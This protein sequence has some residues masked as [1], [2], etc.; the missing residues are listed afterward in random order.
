MEGMKLKDPKTFEEQLSIL[1][2]RHMIV[3][4]REEALKILS[5]TNY[6]RLT[7]YA[8]Q[9]KANDD[10]NKNITFNEMYDLYKFDKKLRSLLR[11]V[12]ESIEISVRTFIAYHLSIKY[13][14]SDIHRDSSI[15][16]DVRLHIGYDDEYGVHHT[17]LLEELNHEINKNRKEPLV[18]HHI[19]KYNRSFPTWAIVE[20]MSFGMLS[21]MYANLNIKDQK[22]ISRNG[23]NTNNNL[24]ESWLLNLAYVRNICAHYGRIY[25]KKMAIQ[26]MVH[27]KY[28]KENIEKNKVFSSILAIKELTINT[29]EWG[30]FKEELEGL[31]KEYDNTLD[32]NL[33]GFPSNWLEIINQ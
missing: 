3:E 9:F 8:L 24:M 12:L 7:A 21:R 10:Y 31:I 30:V 2:N 1:E 15:F 4:D 22:E 11:E 33:I 26:P 28:S 25:N 32:L 17:G 27:S 18:R 19:K 23:F 6:Y 14:V 16:K 29:E 5:R 20:I 13:K